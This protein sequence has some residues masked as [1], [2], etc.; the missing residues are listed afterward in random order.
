MEPFSFFSI[1][2][3]LP[4]DFAS[5]N[6]TFSTFASTAQISSYYIAKCLTLIVMMFSFSS[7]TLLK[8]SRLPFP[9]AFLGAA[10]FLLLAISSYNLIFLSLLISLL[11]LK[12]A[13]LSSL[14]SPLRRVFSI[15]TR[16][17]SASESSTFLA[18]LQ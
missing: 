2:Q 12:I 1:R 9:C 3:Q 6:S 4:H 13:S 16:S 11:F 5:R 8:I 15:L 10:R 18:N 14:F 7:T 17:R